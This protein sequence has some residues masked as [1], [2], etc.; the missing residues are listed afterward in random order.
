MTFI[1]KKEDDIQKGLD[2]IEKD[3]KDLFPE[4]EYEKPLPDLE[5]LFKNYRWASLNHVAALRIISDLSLQSEFGKN[6]VRCA[7]C[8]KYMLTD[9]NRDSHPVCP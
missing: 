5:S 7:K 6:I 2:I 4:Y 8:D 1:V 9:K 3:L